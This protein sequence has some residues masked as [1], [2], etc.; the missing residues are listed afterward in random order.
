M[1]PASSK[2]DQNKTQKSKA[3]TPADR[4]VFQHVANRPMGLAILWCLVNAL[5]WCQLFLP[6][7]SVGQGDLVLIH[8][9]WFAVLAIVGWGIFKLSNRTLI[10]DGIDL[11]LGLLCAGPVVSFVSMWM[12]GGEL[13]TG[14]FFVWSW[15]TTAITVLL[16]RRL[17]PL[18]SIKLPVVIVLSTALVMSFLGIYQHFYFYASA[19][20]EVLP[21]IE[22]YQTAVQSLEPSNDSEFAR[23][24]A[25]EKISA[26]ERELSRMGIPREPHAQLMFVQRLRDSREPFGFF[27][28]ANTLGGFLAL[29]LVLMMGVVIYRAVDSS[30]RIQFAISIIVWFIL[31]YCLMLTKSRTA[32]VGSFVCLTGLLIF[33]I[34]RVKYTGFTLVKY[35]GAGFI[36]ILIIV[37][38]AFWTGSLDVQVVLE[39]NKSLAYRLDY[40]KSS[41]DMLQHHAVFGAGPGNFRQ[42]YLEYKL[43]RSSEEILDPHNLWFDAW[44]NGGLLSLLG[45]V[46]LF[47]SGGLSFLRENPIANQVQSLELIPSTQ[48]VIIISALSVVFS[49]LLVPPETV[50]YIEVTGFWVV[51]MILASLL[52]NWLVKQ[53]R[54][55]DS[56]LLWAACSMVIHLHGAG[57]FSMP[58]ILQLVLIFAISTRPICPTFRVNSRVA[59]LLMLGAGLVML[60]MSIPGVIRPRL[61][62]SVALS[63]LPQTQS[64]SAYRRT[65]Q[66]WI[67]VDGWNPNP[68]FQL[69]NQLQQ[70]SKQ[71]KDAEKLLEACQMLEQAISRD[72]AGYQYFGELAACQ[73]EH[74]QRTGSKQ[75]LEAALQFQE[76]AVNRYPTK[77]ELLVQLADYYSQ[78]ERLVSAKNTAEEAL[79]LDQI[80]HQFGHSDRYLDEDQLKML[81]EIVE[82][83]G[84]LPTSSAN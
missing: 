70:E 26:L 77:P 74:F 82:S 23:Q 68:W 27:A 78:A 40:W 44:S 30:A 31:A 50:R 55:P 81:R 19:E 42:H 7:E 3:T 2:H 25:L 45:L 64:T 52:I 37:G 35:L 38:I 43:P 46:G 63:K 21:L 65:I 84:S 83:A 36:L 75:S 29:A 73:F 34:G 22:N 59:G 4:Q 47:I 39:S 18:F 24:R 41:W 13:R 57:G 8:S 69:S 20:A 66:E 28:L 51:A 1:K 9:C 71:S 17:I 14:L 80:N 60:G 54:I 72:P 32:W 6:A 53:W 15:F 58:I 33:H 10:F 67:A 79:R 12:T 16:M 49:G 48:N 61:A 56:V 11:F 62:E 76:K 5:I